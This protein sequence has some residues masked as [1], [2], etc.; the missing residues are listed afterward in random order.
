MTGKQTEKKYTNF[1]S[2]YRYKLKRGGG[3]SNPTVIH[4]WQNFRYCLFQ[5]PDI[6]TKNRTSG[7]QRPV[8]THPA[9]SHFWTDTHIN[10]L[11]NW[12]IVFGRNERKHFRR[13]V[14]GKQGRS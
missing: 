7:K 10:F 13:T 5:T 4:N 2:Q 14:P 11:L 6:K 3:N 9:S 8:N 12:W 1:Y